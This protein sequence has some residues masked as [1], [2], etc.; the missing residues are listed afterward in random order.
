MPGIEVSTFVSFLHFS[1]HLECAAQGKL[2]QARC[3]S[4]WNFPDFSHLERKAPLHCLLKLTDLQKRSSRCT[5]ALAVPSTWCFYLTTRVT[6]GSMFSSTCS[7]GIRSRHHDPMSPMNR[8][9]DRLHIYF[10]FPCRTGDSFLVYFDL[11]RIFSWAN[12]TLFGSLS[13]SWKSFSIPLQIFT[14]KQ[15]A[16]NGRAT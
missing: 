14:L 15:R 1:V 4:S 3:I 10:C 6:A 16:K 13:L 5:S 11:S 2:R 9:W 7:F 12:V 8:Y